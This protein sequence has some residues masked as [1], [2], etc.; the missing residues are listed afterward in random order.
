MPIRR[1]AFGGSNSLSRQ[2]MLLQYA[3]SSESKPSIFVLPGDGDRAKEDPSK[4]SL[5]T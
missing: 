5:L 1:D 4:Q 2:R 3:L